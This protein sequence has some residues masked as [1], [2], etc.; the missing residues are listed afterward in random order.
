LGLHFSSF[1]GGGDCKIIS[2][3]GIENPSG[4][5]HQQATLGIHPILSYFSKAPSLGSYPRHQQKGIGY[6]FS[7]G[8]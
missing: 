2:L 7:D 6:N 8:V 4:G 5:I 1:R 3:G